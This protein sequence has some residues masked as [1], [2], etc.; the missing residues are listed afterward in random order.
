LNTAIDETTELISAEKVDG[1]AVYGRDG[2]RI[3]SV[4]TVMLEKR[5]GKVANAV[6]SAGGF[7]GI[8]EKYHSIPWSKLE[9]DTSLGG[10]RLDVTEDQLRSGPTFGENEWSTIGSREYNQRVYSHYGANPYW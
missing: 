3:G 4:K 7:L 6:L 8:G 1:T 10:Y 5:G 2:N 9:Y